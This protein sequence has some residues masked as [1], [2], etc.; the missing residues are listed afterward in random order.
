MD[1]RKI[2]A[3]AIIGFLVL[4]MGCVSIVD[5]DQQE[6]DL[7]TYGSF[8]QWNAGPPGRVELNT[9]GRINGSGT[10]LSNIKD[11]QTTVGWEVITWAE[12]MPY[13]VQLPNN[14]MSDTAVNM[15][16]N[17][18][19]LH[20]NES[21]GTLVD[22][23]GEGNDGTASS[24]V[25][26]GATGKYNTNALS[27]NGSTGYVDVANESDFDFERTS[28]FSGCAWI[29]L[30]T[31]SLQSQTIVSKL[32][33]SSPYTG[34]EFGAYDPTGGS[35]GLQFY[36]INTYVT[37]NISVYV[38]NV[39][40]TNTWYHACFT[41][42]GSGAAS[43]VKLYLNGVSLSPTILYN[44]LSASIL[45]DKPVQIGMRDSSS[46]PFDGTIDEVALFSRVLSPEEILTHYK[47]GI[48]DVSMQGRSCAAPCTGE[49]WS[50]SFNDPGSTLSPNLL[51]LPLARYFQYRIDFTTDDSSY[52]PEVQ[53]VT[54]V[55]STPE[56]T[57][58]SVTPSPTNC[59]TVATLSATADAEYSGAIIQSA[60]YYIDS[61]GPYPMSASDGAFDLV[62]EQVT[63][64]IDVSAL[65]SGD[66]TI[67]IRAQDSRGLWSTFASTT[68]TVSCSKQPREIPSLLPLAHTNITEAKELLKE[69][70]TL[71]EQVKA[72]DRDVS[73]C[74]KLIDEAEALLN[75]SQASLT[76]P[77]YANNL[78]LQ[79][80]E[81]LKQALDCLKALIG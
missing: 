54:I 29:N 6:F 33:G 49:P 75:K 22:S 58:V 8:T 80:I 12:S 77:I 65:S 53:S 30:D 9:A 70:N 56:I 27:F 21:S 74:E 26:Y 17:I 50:V 43:G 16:N 52:T 38:P 39:L 31:T 37:N 36:L 72:N 69:A 73:S 46:W 81:K 57:N 24:G 67:T 4:G 61:N 68:L 35:D 10:Y 25:T 1:K 23:S 15:S 20:L 18:L 47:R 44:N 13:G 11:A 32:S 7:G 19:L 45:N 34:W 2:G 63:A 28:S 40:S 48:L 3:W 60:E 5:D 55:Y 76:N 71:L 62:M 78:A 42:D 41:Y 59:A 64:T 14:K 51:S 66:H 79:A